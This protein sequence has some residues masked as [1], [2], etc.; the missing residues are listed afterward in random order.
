MDLGA[1]AREHQHLA[2]NVASL[3][4]EIRNQESVTYEGYWEKVKATLS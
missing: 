1:E 3:Q 4:S 2:S